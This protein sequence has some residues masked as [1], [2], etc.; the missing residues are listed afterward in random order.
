MSALPAASDPPAAKSTSAQ[1]MPASVSAARAA[2][3]AISRPDTPGWRPKGWMPTP[4]TATPS[5]V[6]IPRPPRAGRRRSPRRRRPERG[7]STSSIG[8]PMRSCAGSASVSRASTRT[9]PGQLDV[10]D[11]V[12]LEVL[13]RRPRT[14]GTWARSTGWSRSTASRDVPR[15]RSSTSRDVHA[16]HDAW[17]GNATT[18]QLRHREPMSSRRVGGARDQAVARRRRS[19]SAPA[20]IRTPDSNAIA[21]ERATM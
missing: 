16:A 11:A 7:T 20:S 8:I 9:S 12:G 13:G 15:R 10:A 17:R 18:P 1:P 2:T 6:L 14:A 4:T 5:F 19:Q 3:A 21:G